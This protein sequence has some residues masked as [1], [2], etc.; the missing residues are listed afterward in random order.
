MNVSNRRP[1]ARQ[2][3]TRTAA[4]SWFLDRGLPLVLTTRARW[5]R[6]WPRSAPM[7]AAYATAECCEFAI[8]LITG[9]RNVDIVGSPTTVEWGLLAILVSTLPLAAVVGWLASRL[10]GSRTRTLAA[11]IAVAFAAIVGFIED[12]QTHVLRIAVLVALVLILTGCGVGAVLGWA[13]RM[14]LS[15]LTAVGIMAV[16][17]LPLVML[18][19]LMFFNTYAWIMAA[20]IS[21]RRLWVALLFLFAIAAAFVISGTLERVRPMLRSTAMLPKDSE[22]LANTPFAAIPDPPVRP[23]LS[24]PERLN[25]VFVVAASQLVQM[26]IV[27]VVTAT[28]F[29]VL[30]LILLSPPLL[31]Q[32]TKHGSSKG[33]LLGMTLPLPDAL[34]QMSLFLAA[35]TFMY[36]AARAVGNGEYRSIFLDP[37]IDDL[38]A[39]LI[40]RNRYRSAIAE[41]RRGITGALAALLHK[42][43]RHMR[44]GPMPNQLLRSR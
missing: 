11:A 28:I 19:V 43:Q 10:S 18:T 33:S 25:V 15:H 21:R 23:P 32:W 20:T 6:L 12:A 9:D 3:S 26:L 24:G 42:F 36:L 4:E 22:R 41:P 14:T 1:V 38:H 7:L 34:I 44:R 2:Q 35:V 17:A 29:L 8:Y 27:A 37:L 13:V 39:N 16:R 5:R 40:A 30:G 31:A